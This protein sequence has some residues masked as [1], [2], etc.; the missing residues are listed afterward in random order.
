[1][2]QH[3]LDIVYA[4]EQLG[5]A[6]GASLDDI[7]GALA[8]V[9][10]H[11]F[12][13]RSRV[14]QVREIVE[15]FLAREK[16]AGFELPFPE[17]KKAYRRKAMDL[18]PD[19]HKGDVATEGA[20][21]EMNAAY[22]LIEKIN[23]RAKE[24]YKQNEHLR[25]E[26]EQQARYAAAHEKKN[27]PKPPPRQA[28]PASLGGRK[29]MAASVPRSI[30]VARLGYL[31][32]QTIIGHRVIKKEGDINFILDIFMLPED[33]FLRAKSYLAAPEIILP[34]LQYGRFAPPYILQDT[35]EVIVPPDEEVPV[36]YAKAF[37]KE[38]FGF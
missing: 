14:E 17:I 25:R 35:K 7:Q 1:M 5:L 30:R 4:Y 29:Y 34:A 18:H 19:R 15:F 2:E 37:F 3:S 31:P 32:V 6:S 16:I 26:A 28:A 8:D 13:T 11:R 9:L 10:A 20:L 12:A 23:Q 22:A 27:K 24:Y 21:K 33:Q 38:A 36:E